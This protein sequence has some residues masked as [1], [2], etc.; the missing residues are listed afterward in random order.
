MTAKEKWQIASH[1]IQNISHWKNTESTATAFTAKASYRIRLNNGKIESRG[2]CINIDPYDNIAKS[3]GTTFSRKCINYGVKG[4]SRFFYSAINLFAYFFSYLYLLN[5]IDPNIV[6]N[7]S[8]NTNET[9]IID[10]NET[11]YTRTSL[12]PCK[13]R[14]KLLN[15][16]FILYFCFTIWFFLFTQNTLLSNKHILHRIWK[17]SLF[18]YLQLY[19]SFIQTWA[20]CDLVN[21][22]KR[23]MIAIPSLFVNQITLINNDSIYFKSKKKKI[24]MIQL[25]LS[26]VWNFLLIFSLRRNWII[27][28]YPRNMFTLMIAP[29]KFYLNNIS[30]FFGKG[31]SIIFLILGQIIFRIRHKDKSY[32]LRTNYTIKSNR[33]WNKLFRD[34]RVVKKKT[35]EKEVEK[36]KDLLQITI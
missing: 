31:S 23:I 13:K 35:L 32:M 9:L 6:C 19:V 36:T 10:Y 34:N 11:I 7:N 29:E 24:I 2:E 17:K 21:W 30:V 28:M 22:D 26:I 16:D 25:L 1:N 33:K 14:N 4:K 12:Y 20:F 15:S 3:F 5:Y 8:N 27:N 18:P